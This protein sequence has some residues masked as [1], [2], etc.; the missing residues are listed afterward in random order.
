M[1]ARFEEAALPASPAA[2]DRLLQGAFEALTG[3]PLDSDD[4]FRVE[5]LCHGGMSSGM[6]S[7]PWW[8]DVGLPLLRAR[9][10]AAY[11]DATRPPPEA[12]GGAARP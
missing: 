12:S 7:P 3:L 9:H 10:R 5:R 6:I 11:A 2:L 8:K 1:Q 4:S